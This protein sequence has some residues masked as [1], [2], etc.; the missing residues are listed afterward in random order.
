MYPNWNHLEYYVSTTRYSTL[1]SDARSNTHPMSHYIETREE[2]YAVFN[3]VAA[4]KGKHQF[5]RRHFLS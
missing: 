4:G 5:I 1:R 2:I 3:Y